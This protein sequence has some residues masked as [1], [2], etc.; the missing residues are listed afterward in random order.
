[1]TALLELQS[2]LASLQEYK[3]VLSKLKQTNLSD[4]NRTRKGTIIFIF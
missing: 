1:L 4:E 2:K 3:E